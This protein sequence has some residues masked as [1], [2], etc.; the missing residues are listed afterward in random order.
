[1]P[2]SESGE[3]MRDPSPYR[4][5]RRSSTFSDRINR[6]EEIEAQS[7]YEEEAAD[8]G[9]GALHNIRSRTRSRTNEVLVNW[10]LDDPENPYNWSKSKKNLVLF[11]T[12]V[13]VI[14]STMGSAL[15]SLA[16]PN[17]VEDFGIT[18]QAGKVLPISVYLI[19]YVFGPIIWGPLSEHFGR[20]DLSFATFGLFTVFTMA[21]ALA[22]NWPALLIFRFFCGAFASSPIAI[23]AGILADVYNDPRTR[24]RAFAIFMVCTTGGPILSPIISGFA[25]PSI[26]W[27]WVFW[28]ALIVAGVTLALIA[29]L[30]ETYGPILLSRRA[31]KIRKEDPASRAIAPRDLESTDLRQLLTVV[32]TRPLRMLIFEPIVTTTCAYLSLVYTIFYMSFQAFPIIFQDVYGLSPGVTGLAYLPIFGGAAVTLPI[33]WAWDNALA[34]ATARDAPWVQREEYRRLPL[35]CLGGPLFVISLFWLGWSAREGVSFIAPMLAGIPFGMGFMLIFMAM[36]N[37]LTDAYEIFAAS[38]NAAAS[39]CRSLFAVVLPLATTPMF[40]RLEIPGACSLLGGLSALMCIIPFVF[41]WKGPSIRARSRF[42]IA[43]RERKEE[44]QRK[45]DEARARLERIELR[46]KEDEKEKEYV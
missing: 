40:R 18:S 38:A 33:F 23:V 10:E 35:A 39:T 5:R 3:T 1:M 8:R 19:G 12:A 13:L 27:R 41:I 11:Y 7:R 9:I 22:P 4:G 31:R 45:E 2:S 20:R 14:N 21:C 46:D 34:R 44:M 42:C 28:I 36:L 32:L 24:G 6:L 26:G 30:P 29:F 43:L 17:I 15:P 16:I 25:G 37:Y